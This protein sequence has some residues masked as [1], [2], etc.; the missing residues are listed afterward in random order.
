MYLVTRYI[1]L[2]LCD[3]NPHAYLDG[4]TIFIHFSSK[5]LKL[6]GGILEAP[7]RRSGSWLVGEMLCLKLLPQFLSH[8]NLT[9]YQ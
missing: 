2:S 3:K 4:L 5:L 7:C 1:S 8:I 6:G 9:C